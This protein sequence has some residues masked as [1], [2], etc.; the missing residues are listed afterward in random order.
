MACF[1][2]YRLPDGSL[3]VDCQADLLAHLKTRLVVPLLREGDVS[4]PIL[5][6]NP[7]VRLD[8]DRYLFCADLAGTVPATLLMKRLCRLDS[9]RD[10]F[11]AALDMLLI[12]F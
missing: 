12:G 1:D 9:E 10:R 5:K 2:C 4:Q 7:L 3:V 6:L 8:D 11:S